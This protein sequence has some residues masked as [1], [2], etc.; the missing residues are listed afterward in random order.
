MDEEKTYFL[1]VTRNRGNFQGERY[2]RKKASD[3]NRG[4]LEITDTVNGISTEIWCLLF[5]KHPKQSGKTKQQEC[6]LSSLLF[7]SIM[8]L[9]AYA[10]R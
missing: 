10:I 9:L 3:E 6:T 1:Y 2:W 4:E 5:V 8:K 7:D